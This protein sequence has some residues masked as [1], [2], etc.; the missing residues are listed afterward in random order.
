MKGVWNGCWRLGC[1]AACSFQIR[2]GHIDIHGV[3]S[4]FY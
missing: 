3:N 1:F 4:K 2:L